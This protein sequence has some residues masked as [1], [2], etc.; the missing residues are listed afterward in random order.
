[1]IDLNNGRVYLSASKITAYLSCPHK[2]RLRYIDQVPT[3][4]HTFFIVGTATH[5]GVEAIHIG[6]SL[7]DALTESSLSVDAA[8]RKEYDNDLTPVEINDLVRTLVTTYHEQAVPLKITAVETPFQI[9]GNNVVLT[10]T[11]DA[12]VEG[13]TVLE[14][15]TS[16]RAWSQPQADLQIQPSVYAF[17]LAFEKKLPGPIEVIYRVIVK[18]TKKFPKGQLMELRTVRTKEHFDHLIQTINQVGKAVSAGIFPRNVTPACGW[19]E[20]R[21]RCLGSTLPNYAQNGGDDE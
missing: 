14:I 1:V 4:N 20:F 17:G 7:Q 5:A 19:C 16:K 21:Q 18:P 8:T 13:K 3:P 6:K 15:K 2:F 12:M 10:G 9:D 11:V